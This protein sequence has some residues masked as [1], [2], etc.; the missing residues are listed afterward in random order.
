MPRATPNYIPAGK[1][2]LYTLGQ[3]QVGFDTNK[4]LL[5]STVQVTS[6]PFKPVLK[7]TRAAVLLGRRTVTPR[8]SPRYACIGPPIA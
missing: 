8:C 1:T 7:D 3:K 4:S 5:A 6:L 2:A